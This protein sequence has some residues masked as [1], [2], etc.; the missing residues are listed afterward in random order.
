MGVLSEVGGIHKKM[1][2]VFFVSISAIHL[3]D[4]SSGEQL[5]QAAL[6]STYQNPLFLEINLNALSEVIRL[7]PL[8]II[9]HGIGYI[10]PN[11]CTLSVLSRLQRV[12]RFTVRILYTLNQLRV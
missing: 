7:M 3:P 4:K 5:L 12:A 2:I 9:I 10:P 1:N 6:R 8:A 11:P